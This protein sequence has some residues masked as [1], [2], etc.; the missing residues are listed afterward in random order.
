MGH[1]HKHLPSSQPGYFGRLLVAHQV[2]AVTGACLAIEAATFAQ[3]GGLDEEQ[4]PVAYNDID[5]CL[6][7]RRADLRVVVTPHARLVHHESA[8]RGVDDDPARNERLAAE[9]SIMVDRWGDS[10]EFDP[11]YSPNLAFDGGGFTLPKQP[12]VSPPWFPKSPG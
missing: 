11:A 4:L 1:G 8:S 7:A 9:L 6:K 12:G 2:A 5:L 10:L 3:L